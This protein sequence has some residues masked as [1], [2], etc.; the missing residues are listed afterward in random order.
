ML[1]SP[2]GGANPVLEALMLHF[3]YPVSC[4]CVWETG[5]GPSAHPATHVVDSGEFLTPHLSL[6]FK[7]LL[8]PLRNEPLSSSSSLCFH[9]FPVRKLRLGLI[10]HLPELPRE[11]QSSSLRAPK[12]L[13]NLQDRA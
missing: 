7:L 11:Y 4:Y 2:Y 3:P 1:A 6:A 8:G 9:F 13:P 5:D 12:Y 10:G